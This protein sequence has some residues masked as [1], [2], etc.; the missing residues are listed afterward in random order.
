MLEI[1]TAECD[2]RVVLSKE[3]LRSSQLWLFVEEV[4]QGVPVLP[5]DLVLPILCLRLAIHVVFGGSDLQP[6]I[7]GELSLVEEIMSGKFN[8]PSAKE[9][10]ALL[11]G[12]ASSSQK[13][14]RKRLTLPNT[15]VVNERVA[16]KMSTTKVAY[17]PFVTQAGTP[18][19]SAFC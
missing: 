2:Y 14:K 7:S 8:I 12:A 19:A 13:N 16:A 17:A 18:L 10:K 6:L 5:L 15:R 4:N 9:T 3:N 1:P 11:K